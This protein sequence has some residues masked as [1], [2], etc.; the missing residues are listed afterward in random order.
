M[1]KLNS[2]LQMAF[3]SLR[4]LLIVCCIILCTQVG[5]TALFYA[6][7]KGHSEVVKLLLAAGAKD[8][9]NVVYIK[10]FLSNEAACNNTHAKC[11]PCCCRSVN[12][13]NGLCVLQGEPVG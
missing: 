7:W 11:V 2:Y 12:K 13:K 4:H 6:G 5:C 3:L 8:I 9:P 10:L 1:V